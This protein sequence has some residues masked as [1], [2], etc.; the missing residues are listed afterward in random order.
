ME[1]DGLRVYS[2]IQAD[3]LAGVLQEFLASADTADPA[4][5]AYVAVQAFVTPTPDTDT[6]LQR[7]RRRDPA[8]EPNGRHRGL[9]P[10]FPALTPT[11]Q[12][13][14]GDAGRGFFIQITA[15]ACRDAA[16]P[17]T[18]GE[19]GG[20]VTFG[21]LIAAQALGDRAGAFGCGTLRDPVPLHGRSVAADTAA[22]RLAVTKFGLAVNILHVSRGRPAKA[23]C[24]RCDGSSRS[25]WLLFWQSSGPDIKFPCF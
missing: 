5:S 21:T 13:H 9:R 8:A 11:G 25:R 14:K 7:L 20:S 12:L 18:A 23:G 3:S 1:T 2:D 17:D 22:D 4:G 10:P 24:S 15:D 16:I 6:A 19:T